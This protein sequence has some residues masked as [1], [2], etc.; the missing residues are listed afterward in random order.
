M[1][2]AALEGRPRERIVFPGEQVDLGHVGQVEDVPGAALSEGIS[3]RF[4]VHIEI[5]TKL[6]RKCSHPV[7][8]ELDHDVEVIGRAW[9]AQHGARD[10]SR[11]H[12]G[13]PRTPERARHEQGDLL[14]LVRRRRHSHPQRRWT[15]S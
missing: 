11:N 3:E 9:L 14:D 7:L 4:L 8:V 1:E 12:V 10:A 6:L 5:R 15:A 13:H 2:L